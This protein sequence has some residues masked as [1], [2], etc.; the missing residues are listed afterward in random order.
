M[1]PQNLPQNLELGIEED[2]NMSRLFLC[3]NG[4]GPYWDNIILIPAFPFGYSYFRPFRYRNKWIEQD[5]LEAI[6]DKERCK[7]FINSEAI[8]CMRFYGQNYK[9]KIVPLRKVSI[10]YISSFP[11]NYCIYFRI[12]QFYDFEAFEQF[13]QA[14]IQINEEEK[15][16][17]GE[18]L[19]FRSTLSINEERF[20]TEDKEDGVWSK[21]CKLIVNEPTLPINGEA[22]SGLFFRLLKEKNISPNF[23]YESKHEGKKYGLNLTEGE[24]YELVF[25]RRVPKLFARNQNIKNA[26]MEYKIPTGNIELSRYEEDF[27]GN[28]QNHTIIMS[29]LKPSGT[30][31]EIIISPK[32]ERV[33]SQDGE[34]INVVT[35]QIP[36][37]VKK[38]FWYRLRTSWIWYAFLWIALF[39]L[40]VSNIEWW[41]K[42]NIP[43]I[44]R[45]VPISA[46]ASLIIFIAQRK[47]SSK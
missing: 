44:L 6:N 36:L 42:K 38:S 12:G 20:A 10:T 19:F 24:K 16:R 4:D 47:V 21:F 26:P 9:D 23:L 39:A 17:I 8:L 29:A 2:S 40:S 31:E 30:C 15:E 18:A 7:D 45:N 32:K 5:L 33:E 13:N 46:F 37:K 41:D 27:T 22:R 1:C 35:F 14:A 34:K 28:Y 11:D 3:F 25:S 43:V